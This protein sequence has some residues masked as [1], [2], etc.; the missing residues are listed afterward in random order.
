METLRQKLMSAIEVLFKNITFPPEK[1]EMLLFVDEI[2]NNPEGYTFDLPIGFERK[3]G[4]INTCQYYDNIDAFMER[5]PML[6]NGIWLRAEKTHDHGD[7]LRKNQCRVR[8][9]VLIANKNY[10]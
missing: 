8:I 1:G 9:R 3:N 2:I 4:P 5:F 10:K 6:Q 7:C